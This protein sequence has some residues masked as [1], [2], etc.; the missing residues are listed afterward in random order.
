MESLAATHDDPKAFRATV[1]QVPDAGPHRPHVRRG[2]E[3]RRLHGPLR[4]E[5][6]HRRAGA[7][8]GRQLRARRVRH[9]RRDGG[10]GARRARLRVRAEVRVA[11]SRGGPAGGR[12]H[13][14]RPTPSPRP[15]PTTASSSIRAPG[16]ACRPTRHGRRMTVDAKTRGIGEGTVQFR[17]KDWGISRQRYWGTPIPMVYCDKDGVQAGSRRPVAG[18]AADGH[19]VH[20]A[21]RLAAG[22]GAGV[23]EHDVSQVRGTRASRNRHD[24][25]VR[26]LI[27]VLRSLHRC[28]QRPAG[29][30]AGQG[31]I[32][33]AGRFL[34][35]RR[36]T[37]DPAPDLLALLHTRLPRPRHGRP[38]RALHPVAHAGHGAEGRQGHVQVEGQR[39]RSGS[40]DRE[41]RVGC[42]AALRDVCRAA[43]ERGRVE[44]RR[45]RRQLS[46][47][48]ACVAPG[49]SLGRAR[50]RG[51]GRCPP[52]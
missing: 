4:V 22:P 14:R 12:R 43:G 9:R 40:D 50:Y 11:G 33:D 2:G 29:V 27:V 16:T 17:L 52:G 28:G 3:G 26:G 37:R 5:P 7:G 36:R 35:R 23:R 49:R 41:V 44:R 19:R 51:R 42:A 6:V 34:Q 24:G 10:A 38:R 47:S 25:H 15:C 13:R 46:I 39:R 32:L 18:R 48:R 1:A 8:L 20:R 31:E 30:F 45:A 21:W